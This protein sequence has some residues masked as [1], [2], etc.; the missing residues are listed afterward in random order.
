MPHNEEPECKVP[1][2]SNNSDHCAQYTEFD[3]CKL[4]NSGY[5]LMSDATCKLKDEEI[6][7]EEEE[8][9][10]DDEP[11]TEDIYWQ[12]CTN[13]AGQQGYLCPSDMLT[14]CYTLGDGSSVACSTF[15]DIV[16]Q[17]NLTTNCS[18]C[19]AELIAHC[20]E[21]SG[22]VCL[23][24]EAGYSVSA[25]KDMCLDGSTEPIENC[26]PG[27]TVGSH[28][29]ACLPGFKIVSGKCQ[30]LPDPENCMQVEMTNP[31][32]KCKVCNVG[33]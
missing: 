14:A 1:E 16:A 4:C 26:E 15:L 8:P 7:E 18:L 6:E 33:Y 24:C 27:Q 28:C 32:R 2:D 25:L 10:E 3:T 13:T 23:Q 29:K 22:E 11:T 5:E 30:A 19:P 21:Q 31:E 20:A 12:P 17:N 9:K